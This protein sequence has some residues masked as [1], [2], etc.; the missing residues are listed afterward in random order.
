MRK[1]EFTHDTDYRADVDGL[2]AV[3]V[4]SVVL[5][6]AGVPGISGG[7]VGVD[8]FFVI[9]GYLIT[10]IILGEMKRDRFT[11]TGFYDRRIR[12]IFPALFF[13][14][15]VCLLLSTA[16]LMPADLADA[17]LS[18]LAATLFVSNIH[19]WEASGYFDTAA[20][21]KPF[22]QTWSLAVKEQFYVAYPLVPLAIYRYARDKLFSI[23]IGLCVISFGL[24]LWAMERDA[25]AAFYL[26]PFVHGSS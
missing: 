15:A 22:L 10:R 16:I 1:P 11:I 6:H 18:T 8:I 5:Y 2:R 9:S 21:R 17:G 26:T 7:F 12:R 3:A 25:T 14:L 13:M 24:S 23:L 20:E 4:G 19:F